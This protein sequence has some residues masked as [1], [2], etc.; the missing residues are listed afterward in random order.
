MKAMLY[1][2]DL[3][4][5]TKFFIYLKVKI[6]TFYF[7]ERDGLLTVTNMTLLMNKS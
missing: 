4:K 3:S 2:I 5:K 6:E 7:S 1:V